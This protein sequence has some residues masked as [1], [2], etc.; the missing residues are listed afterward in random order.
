MEPIEVKSGYGTY[1]YTNENGVFAIYKSGLK[2]KEFRVGDCAEYD[3]YNLSY[4]G[5]IT[6]ISAKTITIK[7][8]YVTKS[9]RLKF[10]EFCWRNHNFDLQD[11]IMKNSDTMQ[12]I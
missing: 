2:V 11:T 7:E 9:H 3:S 8:K 12:Y 1:F 6:K 5:T 4:Y 10:G